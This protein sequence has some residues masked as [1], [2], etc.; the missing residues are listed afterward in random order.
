MREI[1]FRG[2]RID[3][4]ERVE[5]SLVL[6]GPEKAWILKSPYTMSMAGREIRTDFD[7]IA[8]DPTTIG[9]YTNKTD[10]DN[11]KIFEGEIV[12]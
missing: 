5:G 7:V 2:K 12:S 3:N 11:N 9:E 1:L 8:V 10:K 4:G 6:A